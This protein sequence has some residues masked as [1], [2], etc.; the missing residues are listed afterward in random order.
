M[1]FSNEKSQT[2]QLRGQDLFN[3]QQALTGY[4]TLRDNI[5]SGL[6]P[7]VSPYSFLP[8]GGGGGNLGFSPEMLS[9]LQGQT[10]DS[11]N[12]QFNNAAGNLKQMLAARGGIGGNT[13]ISGLALQNFGS[14][15]AA[16]AQNVSGGLRNIAISNAQQA[17]QNKFQ[18]AGLLN[19]IGGQM[20][21]QAVQFGDQSLQ[22]NQ[23]L[24]QLGIAGKQM[25]FNW[26]ALAGSLLGAGLNFATGGMS[27]MLG[28]AAKAGMGGGGM[29]SA[30][31]GFSGAGG[32]GMGSI[33]SGAFGNIGLGGPFGFGS[34]YT[35]GGGG[36][37]NFGN[38]N[39]GP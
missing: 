8:G 28:G 5:V 15:E 4:N 20:S 17:L 7:Y 34:G 30:D 9:A 6:L 14:L 21:G 26:S 24:N 16:R 35:G 38:G 10:I 12:L 2:G 31:Y 1:P 36:G 33:G 22:A 18:A 11:T 27:G 32:G 29:N 39:T 25:G 37:Y 13:P 3:S 23:Q 19:Q